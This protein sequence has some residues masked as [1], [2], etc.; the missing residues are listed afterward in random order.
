MIDL[1]NG[2]N[3][4]YVGP[5]FFGTPLQG[6]ASDYY[7]YDT[8]SGF[9]TVTATGCTNCSSVA[10]NSG[11]SSTYANSTYSQSTLSY[12]SA[13]LTGY[14]GNDDVCL[15]SGDPTSCVNGFDFFMI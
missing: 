13:D 5:V 9:L 7:V 4:Q 6:S 8:G 14:M 15:V 1:T 11:L 12:G 2:N 3:L 10:Y